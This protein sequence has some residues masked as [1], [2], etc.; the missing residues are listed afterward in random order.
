MLADEINRA[1]PRTQSALLEAMNEKQVTVDGVTYSLQEPFFVI[2]TQNPHEQYG[3]YPLPE[4]QLDRF[5]LWLS[6]GYPH[7]EQEMRVIVEEPSEKIGELEAPVAGKAEVLGIQKAVEKVKVSAPVLAYIMD[8]VEA[9]RKHPEIA[10]GSS[11]RGAIHL[12]RMAMALAFLEGRDYVIPDDVK[13]VAPFVLKH[14]I[15]WKSRDR[16]SGEFAIASIRALVDSVT[17][18]L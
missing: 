10:V 7:R 6:L 9:T 2:A 3:T 13:K 8:I 1:T 5:M 12:K 4:S 18:R 17:L 14:R 15:V 16:A 11:T